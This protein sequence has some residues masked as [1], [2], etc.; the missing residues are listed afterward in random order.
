MGLLIGSR[1][2]RP[3]S[4][5]CA[6]WPAAARP[7]LASGLAGPLW[8]SAGDNDIRPSHTAL[9]RHASFIISQFR[10]M[11][12][13]QIV[14]SRLLTRLHPTASLRLPH[15]AASLRPQAARRR[16]RWRR[17][18]RRRGRRRRWHG[19]DAAY[20]A[21]RRSPGAITPSGSFSQ[22]SWSQNGCSCRSARCFRS[23]RRARDCAS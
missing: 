7:R 9:H 18:G 17:R 22:S 21:P 6:P 5:S 16:R 2:S 23:F 1:G 15:P 11:H 3:A 8:L 10:D 4:V 20:R 12:T 19:L 14:L 13:A